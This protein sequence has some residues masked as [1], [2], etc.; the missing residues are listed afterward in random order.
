MKTIIRKSLLYKTKVEYGDFTVNHVLGCSHGCL[1]PCYAFN[2]AKRFGHVKT[3]KEWCTPKLVSNALELLDEELP[4]YQKE[5][6]TVQLCFMT[7]PFMDAYPEV[8]EM[9]LKII[10]KINS[11]K[12]PC[13]ILTK[14][15]LPDSLQTTSKINQFGI[16]LV[17]LNDSFQKKYE[18]FS[19]PYIQRVKALKKLH[20]NGFK[21]WVSIEPFPTP[22]I[23]NTGIEKVLNEVSFVDRIVFGRLHYNK[24]VGQYPDYQKFYDRCAKT[25]ETFCKKNHI[26]CHIKTGTSSQIDK[27]RE[28]KKSTQ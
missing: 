1:F 16:T 18:P 23:D 13:V 5:I 11:Y 26:S 8:G 7:D 25:V 10:Q 9:S 20:D 22:N 6:K 24:L 2:M 19:T 12:I 17:S 14:G 3:Y 27:L 15:T 28:S 21:T 4:R